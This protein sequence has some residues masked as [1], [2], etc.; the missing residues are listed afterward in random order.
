MTPYQKHKQKWGK[1]R[2]CLLSRRRKSVVLCR[3]RIPAP[4]L[5]I[6]EA[7]GSSE[8]VLGKPFVGPAGKLLDYVLNLALD[9]QWDYCI[10]NL[11]ACYPKIEKERGIN[12]P[13][14]EAIQKCAPR[15][16]EVVEMCKPKLI[17]C[18]GSL[19]TKYAKMSIECS[20]YVKWLDLI[21]PAAI[22]RMDVSQKGLAIQRSIVALEDAVTSL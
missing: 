17:V 6:G 21:H 8:D 18:L 5:F 1:C 13:P 7:P 3:G 4:I 10:T 22:L 14:K 16:Q 19:S 15:L 11:V 2:R 12:E 20:V 9:G